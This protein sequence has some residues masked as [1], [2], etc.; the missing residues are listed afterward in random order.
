MRVKII[1]TDS[2]Q[3]E[4]IRRRLLERK[5][6]YGKHI[7][8]DVK[9]IIKEIRKRGDKGLLKY[10]KKFD[11]LQDLSHIEVTEEE[12]ERAW[13]SVP[14]KDIGIIK[15]AARKIRAFHKKQKVRGWVSREEGILLGQQ[16]IPMERVG[17][18]VP[19]G[20]ALYPST[21]LMSAIPARIA[22]VNEIIM[23][24]P[25]R[26]GIDPYILV[27]ARIGGVNRIYKAGGAQA[28]AAMAYG[29]E[30]IP[31]VDKIVGPGNIY[32]AMAKKLLYGQVDIDMVAGPS[33]ILVIADEGANPSFVAMDLLS[34]A[35]HDE[36]AISILLTPSADL[37]RNV[38]V[39]MKDMYKTLPRRDIIETSLQKQGLIC[40]TGSLHEAIAISNDIA[41]EHL[42]IQVRQPG[43]VL[44]QIKHAGAIFLGPYT[45]QT[46]G[47]YVAGPNHTLPT[48][49]TAR[50]FSPLSVDDFVKKSSIIMYN[51]K[52]LKRD[53]PAAIR[54]AEIEGLQAHKEAINIRLDQ[55]G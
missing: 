54:M 3:F 51:K 55:R 43:K 30:T 11:G 40:I 5:V 22:G 42:S 49:G 21:V 34:Q 25:A 2:P 24:T 9:R 38:Y 29:T 16:V 50:F 6:L 15:Y 27:A 23:C 53:G 44:R 4:R 52:A 39:Q 35:E 46:I 7:E 13:K 14:G 8:E 10:A 32:V 36:E 12:I 19:G 48:G 17:L 47:D 33:E 26:E 1:A 45:P 37:A 31:R 41:P 20:K 28:I 18:Y